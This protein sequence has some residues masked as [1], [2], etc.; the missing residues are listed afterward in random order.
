MTKSHFDPL[1]TQI[2]QCPKSLPSSTWEIAGE[3]TVA[4]LFDVGFDR[5][6]ELLLVSS[7]S[8]LRLFDC[9]TGQKIARDTSEEALTDRFLDCRGIG[10][11][12][13]KTIRMA[14]IYGGGLPSITQDGW[15]VET[16]TLQWPEHHLLLVEPNSWLYGADYNRPSTFHK[17]A[18]ESDVR[19][20]GFS[21]SGR[22]LLIATSGD[23]TF[24]RRRTADE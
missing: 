2:S 19:A 21:Y 23:I 16:V 24:Y 5:E 10:A 18:T 6:S 3:F 14:G 4:N 7:S 17:L 11:L 8:G 13:H 9:V 1:K 20:F 12:E 15:Q 22:T